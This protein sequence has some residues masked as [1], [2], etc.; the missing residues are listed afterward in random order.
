MQNLTSNAIKVLKND[1]NG[2]I[3]WNAKTEGDKTIL[4]ITD[5]GP[6]IDKEQVKALYNEDS[7]GV[8]ARTGFGFHLIRDLAK[9]IKYKISI[10]SQPGLGTT[11][12]L[13]A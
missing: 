7:I 12:T 11:F 9:A 10:Q 5:N 3:E 2:V 4:S 6:G 8:N 1:P 13:S